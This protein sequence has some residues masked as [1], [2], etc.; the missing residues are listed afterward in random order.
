MRLSLNFLVAAVLAVLPATAQ[1]FHGA[2]NGFYRGPNPLP[3]PGASLNGIPGIHSGV[4]VNGLPA[5]SKSYPCPGCS[6]FRNHSYG[7]RQGVNRRGA[8]GYGYG[9]GAIGFVPLFDNYDFGSSFNTDQTAAAAP[10]ATDPNALSMAE[11]I[12][13]LRGELNQLRSEASA[14]PPQA[15]YPQDE[16]A[17]SQPAEP[18]TVIVL[19]DGHKLE[20]TNYAVMDQTLWNFSAKPVQKIPLSAVDLAA[21]EKANAARGVDFSMAVDASN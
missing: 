1:Q 4:Y 19:R 15:S 11:Q 21:S 10:P 6:P 20:T 16:Q 18:A 13:E 5:F 14:P 7:Y 2:R 12:G 17:A 3:T 9:Y 8:Y